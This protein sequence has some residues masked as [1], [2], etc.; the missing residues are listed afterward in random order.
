MEVEN[1]GKES[2]ILSDETKW[3]N[4]ISIKYFDLSYDDIMKK[5]NVGSKGT[6]TKILCCRN[7]PQIISGIAIRGEGIGRVEGITCRIKFDIEKK[8]TTA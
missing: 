5:F 6:I 3:G 4:V 2:I 1:V 8:Y 7:N